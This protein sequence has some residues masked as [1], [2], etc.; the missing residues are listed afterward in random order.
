MACDILVYN[1]YPASVTI[2]NVTSLSVEVV[3]TKGKLSADTHEEKEVAN[4]Y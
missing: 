2:D 1:I 3:D 4:L